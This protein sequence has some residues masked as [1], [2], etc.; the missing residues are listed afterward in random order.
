[1]DRRWL[2]GREPSP[3]ADFRLFCLPYAGG[4]AAVYRSWQAV[5]P[6]GMQ[7]LPLELPGRGMR[8]REAPLWRLAPLVRAMADALAGALDRPYALF[9]HSLG[10]LLGFELARELRRRTVRQPGRLFVSAAGAPTAPPIQPLLHCATDDEIRQRLAELGGTPQYLL[11]NAELMRLMLPVLRAD[12]SVLE[13]YEYRDEVPLATPLTVFGGRS[14]RIVPPKALDGW[15]RQ[16]SAGARLRLFPGDH[17]FLHDTTA[18]VMTAVAQD[19]S[20]GGET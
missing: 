4:S 2:A 11:D 10:G 20:P 19:I 15:R 5:A 16:T 1:M 3:R 18:E 17:F 14:D 7:V 8:L 12:F 9:G 6:A 13:T